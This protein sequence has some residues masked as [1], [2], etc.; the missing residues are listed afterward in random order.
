MALRKDLL[1]GLRYWQNS[2]TEE[3]FY[4][5]YT[6]TKRDSETGECNKE[7]IAVN[8]R[9]GKIGLL[10]SLNFWALHPL[11]REEI[12]EIRPHLTKPISIFFQ[13]GVE[14]AVKDYLAAKF[15]QAQEARI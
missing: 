7:A 10:N 1:S 13:E 11:P 3:I 4:L 14:Q 8:L 12:E 2:R 9:T 15:S 6:Q 5:F